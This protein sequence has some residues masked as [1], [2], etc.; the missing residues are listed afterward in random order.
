M[1]YRE[2]LE[3]KKYA[4]IDNKVLRDKNLTLE[5]KGLLCYMLGNTE[6]WRF[7]EKSLAKCTNSGITKVR[8]AIKLLIQLGYINRKRICGK[9][10]VFLYMEYEVF[11]NPLNYKP[12]L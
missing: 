12:K 5:A 4:S 2:K 9:N 3:N 1:I 6:T 10:G 7:N 11:E 8:S